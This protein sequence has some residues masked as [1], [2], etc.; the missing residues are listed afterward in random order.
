MST[1]SF[2]D[3]DKGKT[4]GQL[5]EER[6]KRVQDALALRQPDR[7]PVVLGMSYMLADMYGLTHQEQQENGEKELECLEK[8]G[9][10]FQPDVIS[11]VITNPGPSLAV[12]DCT[13]RYPGHG[14][15]DV[16][17]SYQYVEGEFM[18]AEEYDAFIDDPAD[19][20]LRK[21]WPR[22]FKELEGLALLPPLG[23]AAYG[24][25]AL[26]LL[27]FLEMPPVAKALEALKRAAGAQAAASKRMATTGQKMASLG[28]TSSPLAGPSALAPFDFMS[29][30]LRGMRGIML[31]MYRHPDK[32]LAAEEKAI[33]IQTEHILQFSN[34]TG[35]KNCFIPLH[36]GS[37]GFM[38][39]KQFDRFYWPQLKTMLLNIIDAGIRPVIF[40]EGTWDQRLSYL[41]ELPKGKTVGIFQSSDIFRVKEIVGDTLCIMGGMKNSLL[42]AGAPE[43]VRA[44]TIELC[45]KVGKGGGFIMTTGVGEMEGC[46]PDLV[47]VWVDTTKEYGVY[48]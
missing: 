46:K 5:L 35:M 26:K 9:A 24:A 2:A 14:G 12:G 3:P 47:K 17:G 7:I 48:E 39:L 44:L 11:G 29:N 33:R 18:K 32:L 41:T 16:N 34:T 23:I 43:E 21:L 20:C 40:Y 4:P 28:F 30:G 36:R 15:M 25:F 45:Q 31:D 42:Q 10:Y 8:A 27:G 38:A 6:T 13:S 37:D 1:G 19:W 22:I